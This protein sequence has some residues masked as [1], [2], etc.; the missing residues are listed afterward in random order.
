MSWILRNSTDPEA[1]DAAIRLSGLIR[2]FDEGTD[3]NLPYDLIVSTMRCFYSTEKL[4]LESRERAYYSGRAVIWIRI[5][6]GCKSEEF[7]STFPP[8]DVEYTTPAPDIGPIYLL[9][10]N[11]GL[12]AFVH[13]TFDHLVRTASGEQRRFLIVD[14]MW[15]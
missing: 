12:F 4:Y 2:W 15:L 8:P 11:S 5:L 6:T 14:A 10:A 1:L 3:A 9:Q 13:L 7:P